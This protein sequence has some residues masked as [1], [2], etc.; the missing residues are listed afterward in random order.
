[1]VAT[2]QIASNGE[3]LA[4]SV[5][6]T[7]PVA[8]ASAGKAREL[9]DEVLTAIRIPAGPRGD[10]LLMLTELVT[11]AMLHGAQ[12]NPDLTIGLLIYADDKAVHVS[13]TDPG[14]GG[15]PKMR[16]EF[17]DGEPEQP[18]DLLSPGGRGLRLVNALASR[19]GHHDTAGRTVW[20][21]VD[22]QQVA[23]P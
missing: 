5:R 19:W 20:F 15:E 2:G 4:A 12:G 7:F 11:N 6:E 9:A 17:L 18:E 1:M 3:T 10:I 22:H 8:H 23:T 21:Q 14:R 13:V 16:G